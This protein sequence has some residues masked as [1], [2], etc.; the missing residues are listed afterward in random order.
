[1]QSQPTYDDANLILRLY[2]LRR[3]ERLRAARKWLATYQANSLEEHRRLCPPGSDEDA[4]FRMV[5]SYWDMTASFVASGVLNPELFFD[6][7]MELLFVWTKVSAV[8]PEI[9]K[10]MNNAL[11]LS[12]LEKVAQLAIDRW[13]KNDR[14]AYKTF[15]DRVR[16]VSA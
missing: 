4:S 2:E 9:R 5:T 1:M 8:I 12:K 16:G 14:E 6:S 3:E 11:Y 7:G 15:S 13:S 10:V